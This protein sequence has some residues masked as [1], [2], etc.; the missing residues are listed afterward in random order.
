MTLGDRKPISGLLSQ[1][2]KKSL[3][4]LQ[5]ESLAKKY[6]VHYNTIINIRDRRKKAPQKRILKD[7]IKMAINTH[8]NRIKSSE[9]YLNHL[10]EELKKLI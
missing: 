6:N 8:K 1:L 3:T 10:N 7:M 9:E 4:T 5:L 2:L